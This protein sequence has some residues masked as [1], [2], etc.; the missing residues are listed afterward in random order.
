MVLHGGS[1]HSIIMGLI[2]YGLGRSIIPL[3]VGGE[4]RWEANYAEWLGNR[5]LVERRREEAIER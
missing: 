3:E 5:L 2:K 1:E 4:Y